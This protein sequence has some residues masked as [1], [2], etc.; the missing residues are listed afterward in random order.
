MTD[1]TDRAMPPPANDPRIDCHVHVLD[2][3]RFPY[4]P[5]APFHPSGGE[6]A[7]AESLGQVL[8]AHGVR[9]ALI[10]G[11]NSG[12][13]FDNRCL[14]DAVARGAGRYRG[15]A[16][17]QPDTS[18]DELQAL[19]AAGIVGV[20]FQVAMFGVE[21]Y[22]GIGPMLER[23]RDVGMWADVQVQDDQ[24]V[25]IRP[26]LEGS[27]VRIVFDHC[28]RPD[29]AA[30]IGQA[31]FAE[32]LSMAETGRAFVKLSSF[33]KASAMPFPHADA[34]PYVRALIESYTPQALVWG[35]DWP[36]LRART[37]VDYG[38]QLAAL[39]RWVPD[40]AQRAQ[41]LWDNP[42]RIFGFK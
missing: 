31:G 33:A 39:T 10:V 2:P 28:G 8:D 11:P 30:G 26:L 32:L 3:A 23:M 40:P 15:I 27:G 24:L 41:I 35:S 14:L 4:S 12:Y 22:R 38:P 18:R 34:W 9:H 1:D 36:F 5:D 19:Q 25:S 17:L 37:R 16:V 42:S 6:I 29:P 20:A 21:A 13:Q 7:T